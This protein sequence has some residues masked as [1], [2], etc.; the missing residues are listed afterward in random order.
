[1]LLTLTKRSAPDTLAGYVSVASRD[2]TIS[3][4]L[5]V[6]MLPHFYQDFNCV[7]FIAPTEDTPKLLVSPLALKDTL[8]SA[9]LPTRVTSEEKPQPWMAEAEC[10]KR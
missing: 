3:P 10:A 1:M 5:R 7:T 6:R 4:S 2:G 8:C 9:R